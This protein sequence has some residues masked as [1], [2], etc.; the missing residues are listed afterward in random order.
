MKKLLTQV[1]VVIAALGVAASASAQTVGQEGHGKNIQAAREVRQ[2]K[3]AEVL[4]KLNLTS[5]QKNKIA[6]MKLK[7]V[8]ALKEIRKQAR[9]GTLSKEDAMAKRKEIVKSSRQSIKGILTPVQ[10]KKLMTM[11]KAMKAQK[12]LEKK[13]TIPPQ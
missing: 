8:A 3:M 12:K 11:L 1:L 4:G 10:D 6:E 9:A 7:D 5:D 13:G 2:K